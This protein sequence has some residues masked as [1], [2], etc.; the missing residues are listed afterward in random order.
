ME[1]LVTKAASSGGLAAHH[2]SEIFASSG[3]GAQ[4]WEDW[5]RTDARR[6]TT[7]LL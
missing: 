1:R 5:W 6:A 3:R 4:Q 2:L 7:G